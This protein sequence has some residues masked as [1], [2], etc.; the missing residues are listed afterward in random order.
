MSIELNN[1][2]GSIIISPEIIAEVA[3]NATKQCYGII[4]LTGKP[5][6]SFAGLLKPAKGIGVA[7][8]PEGVTVDLYVI[9]QY[10]VNMV[11]VAENVMDSVKFQIESQLNLQVVDV[12]VHIE[13]VRISQ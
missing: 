13:Q 2:Y 7:D 4:G 9:I 6:K 12:N 11:A 5:A 3:E 10:G 1:K 8:S